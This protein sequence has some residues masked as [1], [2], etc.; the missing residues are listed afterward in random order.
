MTPASIR[1]KNPGAMWGHTGK[2]PSADREVPTNNLIA[3]KWGSKTT[4]YLSDGLGQ[5]NNIAVFDTWVHGICAQLDLW[6]TSHNY[7]DKHFHDAIHTWSGGNDVESYI[8]YVLQR[9]PGMTRDTNHLPKLCVQLLC[10]ARRNPWAL[11]H[12]IPPIPPESPSM[13]LT[14]EFGFHFTAFIPPVLSQVSW[15]YPRRGQL[16]AYLRILI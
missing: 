1:Y 7:K 15:G 11:G 5:G 14:H 9:V 13:Q 4:F 2:R 12:P 6:R 3:L 10:V 8:S 16:C